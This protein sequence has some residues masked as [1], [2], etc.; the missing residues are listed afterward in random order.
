MCGIVGVLLREPVECRETL[1]AMGLP[2]QVPD[3]EANRKV[4]KDGENGLCFRFRDPQ[5][6]AEKTFLLA[7]DPKLA[8]RMGL[9]ARESVLARFTWEKTWI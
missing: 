9:R 2:V 1:L 5:D 3:Y 8:H 6:T 4:V 7:K